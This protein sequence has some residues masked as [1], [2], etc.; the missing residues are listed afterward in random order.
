MIAKNKVLGNMMSVE[1]QIYEPR[2][3]PMITRPSRQKRLFPSQTSHMR[4]WEGL[5]SVLAGLLFA[6]RL[7]CI[8]IQ[9][10]Y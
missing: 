3:G 7:I 1:V 5:I 9:C 6:M 4:V 10:G 2:S 8:Q